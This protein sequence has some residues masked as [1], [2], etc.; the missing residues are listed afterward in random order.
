MLTV[1]G[2]VLLALGMSLLFTDVRESWVKLMTYVRDL[3]KLA[4]GR[5]YSGL[6]LKT[7]ETIRARFRDERRGTHDDAVIDSPE[8]WELD[9]QDE[10]ENT[11][12]WPV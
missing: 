5:Y 9:P 7:E 2:V 4:A 12:W 10:A 11:T 1:I 6:D 3:Q 8:Y